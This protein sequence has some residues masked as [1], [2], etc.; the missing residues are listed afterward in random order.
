MAKSEHLMIVSA[1]QK[2]KQ[3]AYAPC[4][5]KTAFERLHYDEAFLYRYGE[6]TAR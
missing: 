6:P 5:D 4:L 3:G 2:I 1:P